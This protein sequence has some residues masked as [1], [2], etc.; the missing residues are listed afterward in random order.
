MESLP[1]EILG[2][3]VDFAGPSARFALAQTT[4]GFNACVGTVNVRDI[5]HVHIDAIKTNSIDFVRWIL[6]FG[7]Q[8][9]KKMSK[10]AIR[11]NHVDIVRYTSEVYRGAYIDECDSNRKQWCEIWGFAIKHDLTEMITIALDIGVKLIYHDY[12][13]AAVF[14]SV[15]VLELLHKRLSFAP[16]DAYYWGIYGRQLSV[17]KWIHSHDALPRMDYA[18]VENL[19]KDG[20]NEIINWVIKMGLFEGAPADRD[21]DRSRINVFVG[22]AP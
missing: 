16:A 10:Y 4:V 12:V 21:G 1:A 11:G 22:S 19:I 20:S 9:T 7:Y 2:Y 18:T 17:I 3:I 5:Y 15:G 13:T 14:G 6:S 8:W